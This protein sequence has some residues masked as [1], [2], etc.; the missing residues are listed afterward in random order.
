VRAY[1]HKGYEVYPVNPNEEAIEGLRTYRSIRDVPAAK[2]DRVSVYLRP[3]VGLRV[4][5][6]IATKKVGEVWFNPGADAPEVIAR[7][8]ELGLPVVCGCSIVDIGLS[9]HELD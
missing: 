4:V 8:R 1:L 6:E 3:A 5:E 2:L 7:A 9:P